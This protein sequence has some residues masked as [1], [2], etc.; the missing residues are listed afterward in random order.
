MGI[1]Q[2]AIALAQKVGK[3]VP[4]C[5]RAIMANSDE[6]HAKSASLTGAARVECIAQICFGGMPVVKKAIDP[7]PKKQAEEPKIE[8]TVEAPKKAAAEKL[9][10]LT[11]KKKSK[12]KKSSRRS[13]KVIETHDSDDMG[14]D[15]KD[16]G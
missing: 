2:D 12:K 4:D 11:S 15:M 1:H 16:E 13:S 6:V 10:K 8:K 14:V 5:K 9:E 3:S 7:A